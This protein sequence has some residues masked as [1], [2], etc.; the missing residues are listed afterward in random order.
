MHELS[1][2]GGFV[3][4]MAQ[5]KRNLECFESLEPA[6]AMWR[7][8]V[9]CGF[10]KNEHSAKKAVEIAKRAKAAKG[11]GCQDLTEMQQDKNFA[12]NIK[13][14]AL[15]EH[16]FPEHYLAAVPVYNPKEAK[17]TV[18]DVPFLLPHEVLLWFLKQGVPLDELAQP[19][20][21]ELH[22]IHQQWCQEH[23]IRPETCI[24][25]GF[26]GD[27][28][29]YQKGQKKKSLWVFN[30]NFLHQKVSERLLFCSVPKRYLCHCGALGGALSMLSTTSLPG[31]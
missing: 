6:A 19:P 13:R 26:H 23:G 11:M 22:N 31:V 15:K 29:E 17:D 27:S 5:G 24:P 9:V 21:Q 3:W 8:T 7:D 25:L 16:P 1:E 18:E 14:S 4:W 30:Y 10:L 2:Q 12:R 20:Y 28:G